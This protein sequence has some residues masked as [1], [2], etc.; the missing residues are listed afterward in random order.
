LE[1]EGF[2]RQ[3]FRRGFSFVVFRLERGSRAALFGFGALSSQAPLRSTIV[4]PSSFLC[5]VLLPLASFFL[6]SYLRLRLRLRLRRVQ[7]EV[8]D[9]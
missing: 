1:H 8:R 7:A 2:L 6:D 4:S 5:L 9:R 3:R